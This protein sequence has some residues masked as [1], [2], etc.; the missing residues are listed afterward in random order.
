VKG[1]SSKVEE[2]K[3]GTLFL[4]EHT[5]SCFSAQ[6]YR[7]PVMGDVG[8]FA[9]LIANLSSAFLP[10]AGM[11]DVVLYFYLRQIFKHFLLIIIPVK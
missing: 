3:W 10:R 4:N 5:D 11:G 2:M 9:A 7:L 1:E 8:A 6:A